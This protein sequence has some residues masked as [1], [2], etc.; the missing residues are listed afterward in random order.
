[1]QKSHSSWRQRQI[2]FTNKPKTKTCLPGIARKLRLPL[3]RRN[4]MITFVHQPEYI[5]WLGF[6]DKLSRCDTFIIYD[7]VQF[8]HGGYQNRNRIRTAQG[9][10]WLT[11]PIN[12]NHPQ[13][14]KDVRISGNEWSKE[15]LRIIEHNYVKT[16]FFNDYFPLLEEALNFNHE[17]LIGLNLHLIQLFSES[18]KIKVTMMR[19]SEFP[20]HGQ[21][22]NEKLISMCRFMGAD[23][24]LAGSGGKSYVNEKL[25]R[26][27][28][29]NILWHNYNH[30]CYNQK[31]EGFQSN[32]SIIDLLFN[33]G[34][35]A[36]E[37]ILMGG[38][39]EK[40]DSCIN[41]ENAN[42]LVVPQ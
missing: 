8:E 29:I 3:F 7:D 42:P 13:M 20:Y 24:Y 32:M 26:E 40:S 17:L 27:A 12:H 21:E 16:P 4:Q 36:K 25:F 41:Q 5:P 9:W 1:M 37:T 38:V 39:L 11:V 6:F 34:P 14:I 23:T 15:H 33:K 31:F 18:L 35:K 28:N 22:K 2:N 30:P 10:R 19:S